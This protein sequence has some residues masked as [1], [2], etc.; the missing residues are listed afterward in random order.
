M[1]RECKRMEE[2][3]EKIAKAEI[4]EARFSCERIW[5]VCALGQ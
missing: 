5:R 1:K 4:V 3:W 2:V